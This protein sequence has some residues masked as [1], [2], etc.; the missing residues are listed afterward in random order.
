MA[1]SEAHYASFETVGVNAGQVTE[2]ELVLREG[3]S[4]T[5]QVNDSSGQPLRGVRIDFPKFSAGPLSA[6]GIADLGF[7]SVSNSS[8]LTDR[9]GRLTVSP[10]PPGKMEVVAR[11]AGISTSATGQVIAGK[12]ADLIIMLE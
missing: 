7:V 9:S 8:F 1:G 12:D 5:V 6:R 4:L 2:K 10:L 3:G 11:G